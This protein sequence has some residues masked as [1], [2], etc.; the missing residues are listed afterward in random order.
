MDRVLKI[1]IFTCLILDIFI[2]PYKSPYSPTYFF[3]KNEKSKYL[4]FFDKK[5]VNG[6]KFGLVG[7]YFSSQIK[8][9]SFQSR[10]F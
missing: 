9:Q 4:V 2:N 8:C 1:E 6:F 10:P 7:I 3:Q 5:N